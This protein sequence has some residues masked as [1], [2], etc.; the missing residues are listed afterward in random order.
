MSG[1]DAQRDLCTAIISLSIVRLPLLCSTSSP[2]PLTK[3]STL[4][5]GISS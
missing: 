1:V 2:V 4:H 5:N 3:Y